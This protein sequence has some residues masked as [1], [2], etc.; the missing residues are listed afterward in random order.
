[1]AKSITIGG[2]GV[3]ACKRPTKIAI[4]YE[5]CCGIGAPDACISCFEKE[6]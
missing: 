1:M 5:R 2:Y 4:A 3:V 6:H